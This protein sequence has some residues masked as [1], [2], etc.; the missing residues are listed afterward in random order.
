MIS[1]D[2]YHR[3]TVASTI[4]VSAI[5]RIDPMHALDPVENAT[6]YYCGASFDHLSGLNV[7]GLSKTFLLK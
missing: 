4:L 6:M 7:K 5:V 1:T 2:V 3:I